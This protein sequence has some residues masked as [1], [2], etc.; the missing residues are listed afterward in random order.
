MA[1]DNM[2]APPTNYAM[3]VLDRGFFKRTVPLCAARIF[4]ARDIADCRAQLLR[5][6][7]LLK[8][9]VVRPIVSDP[10][11]QLARAGGKCLILRPGVEHSG[12]HR[13]GGHTRRRAHQL[14]F[15][16]RPQHME[17]QSAQ[18]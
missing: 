6:K 13:R 8:Y 17:H 1:S 2:F 9:G 3:R 16:A 15:A 5:T 14:S 10:D 12:T 11:E 7:E 4:R 18:P